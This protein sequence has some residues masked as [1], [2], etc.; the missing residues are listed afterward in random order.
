MGKGGG[1]KNAENM[2]IH[3]PDLHGVSIMTI[4]EATDVSATTSP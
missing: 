1:N 4:R 2:S 3:V